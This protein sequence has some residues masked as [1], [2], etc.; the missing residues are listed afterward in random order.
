MGSIP[1]SRDS[2]CQEGEKMKP[3]YIL[4]KENSLKQ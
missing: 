1:L 2:D 3:G 4:L